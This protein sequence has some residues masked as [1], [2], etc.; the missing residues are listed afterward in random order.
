MKLVYGVGCLT[1]SV[2][3]KVSIAETCL[4]VVKLVSDL[5]VGPTSFPLHGHF[6]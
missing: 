1:P 5:H 3:G 4:A 2:N 6:P